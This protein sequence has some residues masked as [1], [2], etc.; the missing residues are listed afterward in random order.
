M[1]R[2]YISLCRTFYHFV[3]RPFFFLFDAERVH[4]S[5]VSLGNLWGRS[6]F[7][8]GAV[9]STLC[10][11]D[12]SLVQ[13]INGVVFENPIGLAAGFDYQAQLSSILPSVGFGFATMGTITNVPCEGNDPPRLARL[14]RSRSLLVNKGFK[15]KGI[16]AVTENLQGARFEIP[17]GLSIGKTNA[18]E[19]MSQ[20]KAVEDIAA[21]FKTAE[22][23]SVPFGYYEINISCPNL[24]GNVNFYEPKYLEQLLK[25]ISALGIKHPLWVKMPIEKSDEETLAMLEVVS[26]Y[27]IQA[28]IFGNLLKDRSDPSLIK[29]EVARFSKGNFSGKPTQ[30]RSNELI[31]LAYRRYAGRLM[32]VG[33]GGVFS[34]QDAYEKIRLGASL[35]QL[36]TGMIFEGPQLP[37]EIN[38]GLIG[39]LRRDGFGNISEAVGADNK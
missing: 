19:F 36:I 21:A 29:E 30:Q 5:V 25:R 6:S 12:A 10:V 1:R 17:I 22:Q 7:T 31:R 26:K 20:E 32:F 15:N 24:I 27:Q 34:A 38:L 9:R 2:F 23:S 13:T 4:E 18:R 33:C 37:A 39:F 28:V 16:R 35:V 8:R 11:S 14:V 3:A